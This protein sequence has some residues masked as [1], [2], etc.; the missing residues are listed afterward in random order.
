MGSLID[1]GPQSKIGSSA[2]KV[3]AAVLS[4]FSTTA[5]DSP[6]AEE[7]RKVVLQDSNLL[8]FQRKTGFDASSDCGP[9]NIA[10]NQVCQQK[11]AGILRSAKYGN[12]A[13]FFP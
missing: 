2:R 7:R 6:D 1:S 9:H 13:Y 10:L 5:A 4:T 8:P 11:I 3:P 12:I